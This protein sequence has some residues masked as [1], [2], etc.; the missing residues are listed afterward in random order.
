MIP[1]LCLH[2][3]TGR[4]VSWQPVL[5]RLRGV[6]PVLAPDLL[7]HDPQAADEV[8]DEVPGTANEVPGIAAPEVPGTA[9]GEVPGT[10]NGTANEVP[11]TARD[12]TSNEVPGTAVG[13]FDR[14]VD[15]LAALAAAR[16][17]GRMVVAGYSLGARL[18]LGLAVRH[19][20]RVASAVLIGGRA[21]LTDA[22]A[23]Q[24]RIAAD[25][26]LAAALERDG[27]E[28]F[29]RHWEALPL[30][31]SQAALPAAV[32]A[33]QRRRRLAHRP[34]GLARALRRLGLGTMPDYGPALDTLRCPVR[35]LVGGRD[36]AFRAAAEA[37]ARRLPRATVEVLGD[38][39]HNL[40][41]EAPRAVAAII[42]EERKR[43]QT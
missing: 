11:G 5:R 10:A 23:R 26:R 25:R 38:A 29:V 19:P 6:G 33:S 17:F 4:G 43:W 31:A 30:F 39:G 14:E 24:A 34:A 36:H 1:L 16:G 40:I 28:A 2:G 42:E 3:F 12:G 15:R 22:G 21:G 9:F 41:L 20:A 13:G 32:R 8:P 18:G 7:G 37:L 35:L 27:I